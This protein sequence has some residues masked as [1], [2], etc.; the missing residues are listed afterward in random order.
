MATLL[1]LTL[2]RT[3]LLLLILSMSSSAPPTRPR[4]SSPCT[5]Q[6]SLPQIQLWSS[7][8]SLHSLHLYTALSQL[9]LFPLLETLLGGPKL[10]STVAPKPTTG[11]CIL[12]LAT[13]SPSPTI[14]QIALRCSIKWKVDGQAIL[15]GLRCGLYFLGASPHVAYSML[16]GRKTRNRSTTHRASFPSPLFSPQVSPLCIAIPKL[17]ATY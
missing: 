16:W 8:L 5:P 12:V 7:L 9:G 2:L 14:S 6:A 17:W 4:R 13:P 15:Q 1:T 10:S 3:T 11:I